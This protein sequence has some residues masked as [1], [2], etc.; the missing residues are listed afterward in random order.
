M[1]MPAR[2]LNCDSEVRPRH[3]HRPQRAMLVFD[4]KRYAINDGPG[5]RTTIFVKGCPLRCVW[6]HNPE[7][8]RGEPELLFRRTRCIGCNS[9]GI[10]PHQLEWIRG[11]HAHQTKGNGD[12][13][14]DAAA[15]NERLAALCPTTALEVCGREWTTEA[16][17]AE[18]EKERDIMHD[19]GGGV[20]VSGGEPLMQVHG[21]DGAPLVPLLR[22]LGR[23][24]FHRAVDTTLFADPGV[25]EAVA[26]ET[27]LFLAD[28]KVMDA[29]RHKRFTGVS[30][31]RI[32]NN[33]RLLARLGADVQIRIPLI[34]GINADEA[35]IEAVA[36]F[37]S[38]EMSGAAKPTVALLPYH[39]MGRDKHARRGTDYNPDGLAMSVPTDETIRRCIAQFAAYGIQAKS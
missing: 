3:R 28:L 29:D 31:E 20:T 39:E 4:I 22:E 24:G 33:L 21:A 16:L 13:A 11:E 10:H 25:V 6:C 15:Q 5:I 30:N 26:Q 8:W 19:S 18:V 32:L 36:R 7:S 27:D 37:V 34:E 23:R 17:L 14:N 2:T 9:C 38:E 1:N 12:G 35:N